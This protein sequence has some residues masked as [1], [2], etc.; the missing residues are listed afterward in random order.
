MLFAG[1]IGTAVALAVFGALGV[2]GLASRARRAWCAAGLLYAG[3]LLIAPVILRSD[4]ALGLAAILFIFAVVW[5][6]DIAAYFAGRAIGGPKLMP[7]VSPNKTW[8]GAIGGTICAIAIAALLPRILAAGAPAQFAVAIKLVHPAVLAL[9]GLM[10]SIFAQ[11]GDLL[12][13]W[14]K[15]RF[16][17]KD[18]SHL[19]P[20]HGGVMDRLDG[21]WAAAVAAW[22]LLTAFVPWPNS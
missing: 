15:R 21:F 19:I 22:A 17:A 3:A 7:R 14:I 5:F 12:E 20:G 10:L 8:S 2:A 11:L 13:S 9:L 18:A 16:G 6:S 1:W 4:I